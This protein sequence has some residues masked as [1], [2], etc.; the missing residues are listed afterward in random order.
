MPVIWNET[1]ADGWAALALAGEAY[2][3]TEA[4]L[5]GREEGGDER[6]E[7]SQDPLLRRGGGEQWVLLAGNRSGVRVNGVPLLL[8]MHVL[9]DHD[10][11]F[12][13]TPA[14]PRRFYFSTERLAR[15]EPFPAADGA[16]TCPRC[17][18]PIEQGDPAVRCPSSSCGVWHHQSEKWP[19]WTYSDRCALCPTST[20][21]DSGYRWT[22]EEL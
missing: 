4:G 11:I 8:G 13:P 17:K 14:E 12:V 15:V 1:A 16:A 7:P 22:P 21:L 5:V 10:E 19:C 3:L 6:P 2:G 9:G 18:Q 20:A